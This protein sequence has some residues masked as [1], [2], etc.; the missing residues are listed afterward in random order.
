MKPILKWQYDQ[1][2]KELLLLQEHTADKS[3]PCDFGGE[4]CIRKHLLAIEAYAQ[5]TE[6]IE[7]DPAYKEKLAALAVEARSYRDREE[8]SICGK[9]SLATPQEEI[10]DWTRKWRKSF[11]HYSLGCE[12]IEK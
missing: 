10:M 4:M 11:E 6:S 8:Q 9:E 1:L 7:Q 2:L 5:E 3:C 12:V